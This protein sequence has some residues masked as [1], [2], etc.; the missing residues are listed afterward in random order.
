MNSKIEKLLKEIHQ[1]EEEKAN[2]EA[3]LPAHSLRPHQLM[4]IEEVEEDIHRK[5]KELKALEK[6]ENQGIQNLP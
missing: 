5:Q 6:A 4:A 3:A 2:R 1:L